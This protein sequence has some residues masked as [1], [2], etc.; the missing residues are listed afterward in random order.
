MTGRVH[1]RAVARRF[2]DAAGRYERHAG[3][4]R[5]VAEELAA[6]I[7]RLPLPDRPRILE[8]GC[9]TGF[10]AEAL[11]RRLGP[12]QWTLTDVS[13]AMLETARQRLALPGTCRFLAMDGEHP[14]AGLGEFDLICSSMAVQWF[15]DLDAG[16]ARLGGLLAEGGWM[17]VATLADGTFSEWRAVH[18]NHGVDAAVRDYPR[19][20]DIGVALPGL[21]RVMQAERRVQP[22]R[23][24]IPAR[25]QGDRRGRARA[26]PPAVAARHVQTD[27]AQFRYTGGKRD[28][29]SGLRHLEQG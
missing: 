14:D 1:G 7:A 25:A 11:A 6:R 10:L 5:E 8:I 29:P 18:A 13:P 15:G 17:A 21:R 20:A 3:L 4:Q 19:P 2:G 22:H 23:D 24:G 28:L 16:L 12:A 9:G 27:T 26:G